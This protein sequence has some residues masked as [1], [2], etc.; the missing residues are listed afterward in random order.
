MKK[1]LALALA[2]FV[3][4]ATVSE[5]QKS[6][7]SGPAFSATSAAPTSPEGGGTVVV[8]PTILSQTT[9]GGATTLVLDIA[10]SE[11]WDSQGD[12][13]NMVLNV[14]LPAGSSMTGIGWDATVATQGG[15]WLSEAVMYFDGS[16]QDGSG[17]FLTIGVGN[18]FAGT[19]FF[20]SAGIID[21]SDNG[22]A[23]IPVLG[24]N[25]LYIE[26]FESF[27]DAADT[28]D[29]T[30]PAPST[31]TIVYEGGG[32]GAVPTVSEWGLII[33]TALLLIGGAFL[34]VRRSMTE[35]TAV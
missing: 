29:A 4:F 27:D 35:A 12:A 9:V 31:L 16:D 22:I 3:G 19:S 30:Y 6:S 24:D 26:L 17:L 2:A 5:A 33:M 10:G 28:I 32:G 13:S 14:P 21:L 15:S 34:V 20:T 25:T 18:D 1:N 8:T 7:T 23:D 11:S